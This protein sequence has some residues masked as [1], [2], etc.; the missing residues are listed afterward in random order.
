MDLTA[1]ARPA[2]PGG[3]RPRN[4][5]ASSLYRLVASVAL[6][7]LLL[8][9]VG[10]V[11]GPHWDPP[12]LEEGIEVATPDTAIGSARQLPSHEVRVVDVSVPL[13]GASV[14]ARLSLPL[15]L[16]EPA[17]AVLF[18]HGA[19]TGRSTQAFRRQ[20]Q[21]LA[22]AGVVAMVPDKRLDTYTTRHRDYVAMAADYG[23]S[24]ELLR[25][26]PE[27]DPDRVVVYAES[28]GGWIAPVMAAEDRDLAG[29][30]LVSSPVVPPRQQAAFAVDSYLR[31]TGVPHAVFRAIPRAVGMT[32]PGGGF[33]Y[34]DFDVTR[35]QQ[36]VTAPV[37]VV[38]GTADASMPVVQGAL[39]VRADA[40]RAG[41]DAVTIR[42]YEGADHGIRVGGRPTP[43]FLRDLAGWVRGLPGTGD[44]APRVAGAEPTQTYLAGPVPQPRW[45]RDGT[46]LLVLVV[47]APALML[48]GAVAVGVARVARPAGGSRARRDPERLPRRFAPGIAWR[49]AA[50]GG[51]TVAT[52]GALVWYLLAVAR[53]AMDYQRNAW[54]VQGGWVGVRVLGISA[55]LTAV[56]LAR[57]AHDA[58]DAGVPLAPGAVR[59]SAALAVLAGS[60]VLLVV[61]A[62]WGVYQLNI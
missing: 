19:G 43:E 59:R 6:G 20:A 32:M 35:W 46:A 21:A 14:G 12:P 53:L 44:A 33:E 47:G 40:A 37:L 13:D 23:R 27:V 50:L 22:E 54:V 34:A 3:A 17:P 56:L 9:V 48:L 2:R 10:A 41:N 25:D 8:A 60:A 29:L 58:R 31:N 39:Q 18:V 1:R 49:L 36:R 11:T 16:D 7:S 62:Y 57:R 28:E 5:R 15:D 26:R 61:L 51:T 30:V 55:V 4:A 52:V 38:Y 45:L 24:L 42:Y